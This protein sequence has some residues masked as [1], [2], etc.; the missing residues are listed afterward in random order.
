MKERRREIR[1]GAKLL[2]VMAIAATGLGGCTSMKENGVDP[3]D[4]YRDL[5]GASA[6]DAQDQAATNSQN[7]KE[8]NKEP[9]PNLASVPPVPDNAI[10]KADREKL[11]QSLVADRQNAK[12][13][14]QQL[15]AG[16]NMSAVP[17]PPAVAAAAA[18]SGTIAAVPAAPVSQQAMAPPPKAK[19]K[20]HAQT[21]RGAE[22]PP[23]ES[24]LQS[25]SIGA[26]PEGQQGQA[27]PPAPPGTPKRAK[28]P[29]SEELAAAA[30]S[31]SDAEAVAPS[32][33]G[34]IVVHAAQIN[35]SPGPFRA[36]ISVADRK[37]LEEVA[38]RAMRNNARIR[39]VGHGGAAAQGDL[40]QREFQSFDAALDNAKAVAVALTKLGVP[41]SRIDVETAAKV[42][43]PDGAEIFLE[44]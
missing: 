1:Y 9:Y 20:K 14:D 12:Y 15:R 44:Y 21:K 35:F 33:P 5:S 19:A 34:N 30:P 43:S 27:P 8:G 25:P 29:Q 6:H 4:W 28:K 17:P 2:M 11:A 42:N 7:L 24:S 38:E 10:S 39:V 32:G 36:R 13:S 18:Q 16:E 31:R 41:A 22:P 37:Q 3:I 23:R 26:M 40:S